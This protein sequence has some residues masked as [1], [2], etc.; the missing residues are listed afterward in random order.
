MIFSSRF[1]APIKSRKILA[2]KHRIVVSDH[3]PRRPLQ[4][5]LETGQDRPL[6][7]PNRER[8]LDD[9]VF[10]L[11]PAQ[12]LAQLRDLVDRK[13]DTFGQ[14]RDPCTAE[15]LGNSATAVAFSILL[16]T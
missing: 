3:H 9:P 16:H 12:L 10:G 15:R 6:R 4:M 7:S 13:T 5:G 2:G 1:S 14:N 11:D 8:I